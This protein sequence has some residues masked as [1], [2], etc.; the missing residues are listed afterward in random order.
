MKFLLMISFRNLSRQ[1]R[2]NLFL[3]SAMAFG[4]MIMVLANSFSHGISDI[5]FNKIV[6]YV[7]GHVSVIPGEG[8]GRHLAIFRDKERLEKIVKKN[9]GDSVIDMDE[10]VGIFLRA[11]GNGRT[12]NM[13]LVGINTGRTYDEKL[14]KEFD[15]SFHLIEGDYRQLRSRAIE[16][17]VILSKEKAEL[18]NVKR[19]DIIRI[20]FRNIFGQTQSGRL[21]VTGIMSNDNTFMQGVMFVELENLKGMM[22]YRPW[23]CGS[24]QLTLRDPQRD[25]VAVADRI[26]AALVPGPAF[27]RATVTR[28]ASRA[29]AT[30]LPFMGN[31]EKKKKLMA[32]SFR[33]VKGSMSDALSKD[34]VLMSATLAR[35]LGVRPGS[36]VEFRFRPKY[37]K[38]EA[39]FSAEVSG[40]FAPDKWTGSETVYMH[41]ALFYPRFYESLPDLAADAR[42]AFIPAAGAPFKGALGTEWELV[43]RARTT[44]DAKKN[45]RDITRRRVKAATIQVGS[46]YE[47]ASDVLKLEGVLNLI[48]LTAVLV[49]FFIILIGVINTLRM[50]IRERT[51][52]IGT[53]RAIGMQRRDV[54]RIFI[55]ET[56]F[57]TLFA[58]IAG[59]ILAFIAMGVLSLIPFNVGDNPMGILLVRQH[60]HFLPTVGGILGNIALIMVIAVVTAFFPARRAA[61]L[62]SAEAL[63]H[64]E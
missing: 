13:V 44:D 11:I 49:L 60:L 43:A 6:V 58:S 4:V 12:E 3:G 1:K 48:T 7:A 26:H 30:V 23:E 39:S 17:P 24:I 10:G 63:R 9:A 56:A 14:L 54:R 33:L 55:L 61:N 27:I 31:D 15:E 62:S 45:M 19:N 36:T 2:R 47:T 25:A 53:I 38:E 46:M 21:T 64:F 28:G 20:R 52:E 5:L 18:L 42:R 22:G 50:T 51:R 57:L 35:A 59:V 29:G 8:R 41:E 16:N 37:E 32:D 40:I 34:G